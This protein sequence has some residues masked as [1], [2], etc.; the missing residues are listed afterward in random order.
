MTKRRD[1]EKDL[2]KLGCAFVRHGGDHDVWQTAK[3]QT[4]AIPRHNE[5]NKFTAKGILKNAK[6]ANDE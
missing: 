6:D 3:G 5:I 2:K 1:L 4:F